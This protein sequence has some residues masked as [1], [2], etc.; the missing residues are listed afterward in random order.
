M[1]RRKV[2]VIVALMSVALIG[3]VSFQGYWINET[4]QA[5]QQRFTQN[6]HEAL[7]MVVNQLEQQEAYRLAYQ[8]FGQQVLQMATCTPMQKL[9]PCATA[10]ALC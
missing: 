9:L 3:L 10:V 5:N 7:N 4:V 2:Y 8:T 1:N 6:V